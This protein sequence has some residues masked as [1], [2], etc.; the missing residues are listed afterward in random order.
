M[1]HPAKLISFN[2]FHLGWLSKYRKKN[3][4]K[5]D[6]CLK[7]VLSLEDNTY[8][9]REKI[10]K[11]IINYRNINIGVKNLRQLVVLRGLPTARGVLK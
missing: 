9:I 10:S 1:S 6:L 3:A 4:L 11:T 7:D 5:S 2:F 8:K